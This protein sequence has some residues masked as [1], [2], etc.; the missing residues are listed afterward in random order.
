MVS[1]ISSQRP[2]MTS[3]FY[4]NDVHGRTSN[5]ERIT[6][7]SKDFDTFTPQKVDKLKFSSGDTMLGK[8]EKVNIAAHKFLTANNI[9]ASAIGNHELDSNS[10][11]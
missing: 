5:M 11:N 1:S 2:V 6:S 7:A 4:V 8:N 3:I 9:M 10:K